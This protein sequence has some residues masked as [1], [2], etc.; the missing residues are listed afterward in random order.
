M[1]IPIGPDRRREAASISIAQLRSRLLD[2]TARN[3]LVSFP[4]GRA[5]GTRTHVRAVDGHV[6][7]LF[8]HLSDAKQLTIR[9]LPPPDDEPEDERQPSF[10]TALETARVTDEVYQAEIARLAPD[11]MGSAKAATIDR[12]L[13]DRVR[14][15]LGLPPRNNLMPTALTSYAARLGIDASFDLRPS[16][17]AQSKTQGRSAVEFQALALPDV[18]ERQ[19]AKIRDTAR[20]VAEETGVST[21]HLAFGFLEWFESDAS[22]KPLTSPLLLLR[23]DI[24]RRIVR[25]RYQYSVSAVGDEAEVNLTLS[26][27]LGRDFHIKLPTMGEED[28]PEAYFA[29]VRDEVC[30]NR[31]RWAVRCFVT[32]S[33]FPF[34]RLAMFQDLD[35]DQWQGGLSSH[36]VLA[37]L[38]AGREAGESMFAVE[39]D[40]DAPEVS[41]KVPVLVLDADASQHS[42]IYDVMCGKDLVIEGPPGTGK[43]QTITNIIAAALSNGKRVLF[44]ADKQAAL[45]VVK[46]RLDKVGL[47]DFCLELHSGKARKTDVLSSLDRRLGRRPV[48]V[49]PERLDEKLRELAATRVA[50]TRYVDLLNT[51]FGT[52]GYSVHDVL[53]ADRRRRDGE[54]TEAR[55]LD[56][57]ALPSAETLSAFDIDARRAVL[58]RFER[59]AVPL[60]ANFG[61]VTAHPW[62]SVTRS[63]LPSIDMEQAVRDT[64]DTAAGMVELVRAAKALHPFGLPAETALDDLGPL[65]QALAGL[66]VN[67][68][69]PANWFAAFAD[70]DTRETAAQW[71]KACRRYRASIELQSKLLNLPAVTQPAEAA[72]RIKETWL[73]IAHAVPTDMSVGALLP[74]AKDLQA[75]AAM[76]MEIHQIAVEVAVAVGVTAPENLSEVTIAALA[77]TLAAELERGVADFITPELMRG[78]AE[79]VASAAATIRSA[80]AR[81]AELDAKYSIPPSAEPALLRQ[82]AAALAAAGLFGFMSPAVKAA[83]LCFAGL[84]RDQHKVSRHVMVAALIKVAEHLEAAAKIEA[85]PAARGA[86]GS[87]YR[88]LATD[89]D[90]AL[91]A[92]SWATRVRSAFARPGDAAA[93][94]CAVL[95][96]GDSERLRSLRALAS[97][98]NYETLQT[99]LAQF[100]PTATSFA[101]LAARLIEQAKCMT[102]VADTC[103]EIGVPAN[104]RASNLPVICEALQATGT[105]EIAARIPAALDAAVLNCPAPLEEHLLFD[106]ALQ[107]GVALAQLPLPE[108]MQN[109]LRVTSPETLGAIVVPAA[110][111]AVAALNG[112]IKQWAS[113]KV[114]LELDEAKLLGGAIGTAVPEHIGARLLAAASHPDELGSWILYL[115]E[116][117]AAEA[118]GLMGLLRLW[119]AGVLP[120]ALSTAFD[121]VFHHALARAVFTRHPGLERFTGMGQQ[122]A[123]DR[124]AVL[125]AETAALQRQR[126]AEELGKQIVP[127]GI[128]SGRR[129]DFTQRSLIFLEIGKQKRHIPIR[130]LLDRAGA[131]TQALKPCFMMSPLSVAQYLKPGG[132]RFD[133]LVIDEASQM[134]PEDAVG[135]VARCKQIV[136]VG[137]PKQLPPSAF[138]ARSDATDDDDAS[139]EEIDAESILDLAQTVFRPMRRLRWHY[140]SRHGSLIAFSNR[141]FY[142]DDLI[143]FPSPAEADATQGVASIKIDGLY[144]ARSNVAE[145]TAVCAAAAEHMRL[146]PDR[147]LGI[148]TMNGIQRDLIA[149]EMDRLAATQPEVEAYRERWGETLERFF[150]KNLENVQGDERDIIFVSTVFG[151]PTPGARVLQR[152]GPI[153]GASGHRRLNVLF[154]RAKHHVRLFT[155]M[156]PDDVLAGP[157]SPRGAQVLKAYLTYAQTGRLEAGVE[158]GL[159]AD[160]DFEVF[161]RDRL[162]TAGYEAVPQVG[163]AGFRIDLAVRDPRSSSKFLLGIECD[164]ASYHSSRSARDR[165]IL[166]QQ[167]LE[168]LGWTIYR[169]WSTDWFRD[170]EGQTRKL[171]LYISEI[172]TKSS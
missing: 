90:T 75:K 63:N 107:L 135:A 81:R 82:H 117:E 58:D 98:P 20:T 129:S 57:I 37:S 16:P 91:A 170:P 43:S 6:D 148:A 50:L 124:F 146:C 165:D 9:S 94:V 40:V 11:E 152:F 134:R 49:Y 68:G 19:L 127:V 55:H 84:N 62:W 88:G 34:A 136:V 77:L 53:W 162:R 114:R 164:G 5:T 115:R 109:A 160:S 71:Q 83:K 144:K 8:A 108:H 54:G 35:E 150:V 103:R 21:L 95:L 154:T 171:L 41:A 14:A 93:S 97:R 59:A 67:T 36:P 143:V 163:V 96:S 92:V 74:M 156:T 2:L 125:D 25:S 138:F 168:S 161:V 119:D 46:D 132:L 116:R 15:S 122:E 145:V 60:L 104:T 110:T 18:L 51:G 85:D 13:N 45:Q 22:D 130:Q 4:H 141:E 69:I 87:A 56:K 31:P 142:D 3:P 155:S 26:E 158:T 120:G 172:C 72:E 139:D 133:L 111:T 106:A 100:P 79:I 102:A 149:L 113:L 126:L 52:L 121:R 159:E 147:S 73:P 1:D 166:R 80:Q 33:H 78:S 105:T 66:R 167:V 76:L 28:T 7:A 17:A 27:R 47:G 38:L 153:N 140:R 48:S 101:N 32:L 89:V 64:E 23:V 128:G 118:L 24:D 65:L 70:A 151:P 42:A 30:M 12:K 29:R 112:A 169:I 99:Y 123:R 131:A 39:H 10:R 86:F 137:D 44:V 61:A 157:E